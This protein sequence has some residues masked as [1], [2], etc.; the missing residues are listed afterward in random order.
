MNA[1]CWTDRSL[2]AL[3]DFDA[4]VS[5]GQVWHSKAMHDQAVRMAAGLVA[6]GIAPGDRVLLWLPNGAA[7]ATA[8]RAVVRAGGVTVVAHHAS[9][10]QRIE[11]LAAETSAVAIVTSAAHAGPALDRLAVHHRIQVGSEEARPGWRRVRELGAEQRPLLDPVP[12]SGNDAASVTYTSGTTGTPK[13]VVMTHGALATVLRNQ[14]TRL[15][16]WRRPVRYLAVLPMSSPFGSG[17]LLYGLSNRCTVYCLD[18]F[19][20]EKVLAAI[21]THRIRRLSLV[22]AM[23]EAILAVPDLRRYDVSSLRDVVCGGASV[24]AALAER[25]EQLFGIRLTVVYGMSGIGGVSTTSSD[26]RPGS[27]GRPHRRFEAKIVGP[28]DHELPVGE[29]GEL[30]LRLPPNAVIQYWN[31]DSSTTAAPG[32]DGWYRTGDLA[33]F[34]A[35]GELYIVGRRDDLIIQGG[36]NIYGQTI[37]EIVQRLPGVRECAIVG[38]PDDYLGQE[39]VA[40][41]TLR[42]GARLTAADVIAHCREHLEPPAVP[43]SVWFVEALPRNEAGKVKSHELRAAIQAARGT[44]RQTD[45]VR[46]IEA[47]PAAARQGL[48]RERVQDLLGEVL[49]DPARPPAVA[50]ATFRD[51]GLDSLGAVELVHALSE[52]LGRPLPATLLYT[53]PTVD[54]VCGLLMERLGMPSPGR[55]DAPAGPPATTLADASAL[56]LTDLL[57]PVEL[58]A[59]RHAAPPRR[60]RSDARAILLTGANGFLGRFLVLEIIQRLSR[61]GGHLYCLVRSSNDASALGRLRAAYG[62]DPSLQDLFGRLLATGQLTVLGGDLT[63]PHFG[64]PDSTYTRLAGE[65][66]GI[67]HSGAVV[68]HVLGYRELFAPNVLGTAEIARFAV[69]ERIKTVNYVS[70]IAVRALANGRFAR[71]P[72]P[73]AVGYSAS[74][75]A[76]ERLLT[77]LYHRLGVPLRVYRP[78]RILAHRHYSGQIAIGDSLTRLL[79]GIVVT[80][81]A[82]RSFYAWAR[83]ADGRHYDGLPVDVVARSIAALSTTGQVDRPGL[84]EYDVV[85]PNRGVDLD[86]LVEWVRSAGYRVE[87]IEG[88]AAWYAAFENRLTA[89]SRARRRHSLLPLLHAWRRPMNRSRARDDTAC[90]RAHLAELAAIEATP[91]VAEIP[92]LSEAFIHKCL[93]DMRALELIE[94]AG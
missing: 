10:P 71:R 94:P 41:V 21:E 66:D 14:R 91:E 49:R 73:P 23:C 18:H 37:V 8:W 54:S 44:V 89:L 13:G 35:D 22:P 86:T 67:V 29:V 56:R 59:A 3:G 78:S 60:D 20:P 16:P 19:D 39:A 38:V 69:A 58:D 93:V 26:S 45:L 65:I 55:T 11:Q 68:D 62:T 7:L 17:P 31:A 53:H 27:V 81:L 30:A 90:F 1:M 4:F 47:A 46:R 25:F 32:P 52:A 64:L 87:Y 92:P 6:L 57:S 85:N 5:D 84:V 72:D 12:R 63:R 48:L 75:W 42:D 15:A 34:D 50:G 77:E 79:Q 2:K 70:T 51:L 40:C 9:P 36:Y 33:R 80:S 28:A 83:S 82:P 61:D 76:G 43:A 24:P 88:Y 74:K